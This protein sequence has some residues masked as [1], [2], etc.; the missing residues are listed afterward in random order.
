MLD[1]S[2]DSEFLIKTRRVD[3]SMKNNSNVN[4]ITYDFV[5]TVN[6]LSRRKT[7]D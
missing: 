6:F 4:K 3:S 1:A 2:A 5:A 7:I